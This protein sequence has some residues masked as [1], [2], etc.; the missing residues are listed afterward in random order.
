MNKLYLGDNLPIMQTL[1]DESI[2]LICADPPFNSGKDYGSFDD[3]WPSLDAYLDFMKLRLVEMHRLLKETGSLF[4]Q[5]DNSASHYLK[6]ELDKVFGIKNFQNDII[7][8]IYRLSRQSKRKFPRMNDNI[9]FYSKD[10]KK[11]TFHVQR[12]KHRK[13]DH[14]ER[15]YHTVGWNGKRCLIIYDKEKAAKVDQSRYD[16]IIYSKNTKPVLGQVW[17]DINYLR[18]NSK[19]RVDYQTQKPVKLYQRLIKSASNED[20]LVLDPFAGSGTTLDAAQS[21]GRAW[22]GIDRSIHSIQ[23]IEQRMR[24]NYGYLCE[25]EIYRS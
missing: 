9:L 23:T 25:Y 4:L 21:L 15:G 12:T 20:D 14:I 16:K 7:W 22:I 10:S 17:D 1:E 18:W 13:V 8:C 6:V 2:D 11:N 5:C 19:E 24:N 3:R